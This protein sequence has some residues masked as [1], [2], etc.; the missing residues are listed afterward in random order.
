MLRPLFIA[1]IELKRFGADRGALAFGIALP[2]A[3]F[4]LMYGVFGQ[5]VSFSARA[6]VVDLD[7]GPVAAELIDRL[8]AFDGL[9]VEMLTEAEADEALDRSHILTAVFIPAGFSE[10]LEAGEPASVLFKRR[11]SGGDTGQIVSQIVHGRRAGHRRRVRDT[12]AGA[13]PARRP[14]VSRRPGSW[15]RSGH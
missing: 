11:G 7:G 9:D 1:R 8:S 10:R 6:N 13:E 5:G 15:P 14:A 4:A 2:I 3:L 12:R